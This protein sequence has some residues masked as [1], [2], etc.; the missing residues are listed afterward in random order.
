MN[1]LD[2]LRRPKSC[3]V[4]VAILLGN[5]SE[6]SGSWQSQITSPEISF[7]L[8]SPRTGMATLN[9]LSIVFVSTVYVFIYIYVYIYI[10]VSY[11]SIIYI[12]IRRIF[13]VYIYICVCVDVYV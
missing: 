7:A 1:P 5:S 8:K 11:Y 10:Y 3:R 6:E 4:S 12:Y 9:F 2:I 13:V